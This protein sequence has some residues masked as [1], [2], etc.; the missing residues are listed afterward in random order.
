MVQRD[1]PHLEEED[2]QTRQPP[3]QQEI[4]WDA[5]AD[6]FQQTLIMPE[7]ILALRLYQVDKYDEDILYMK[8]HNKCLSDKLLNPAY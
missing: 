7:A 3:V 2:T 4:D 1:P 6:A 8:K 5:F